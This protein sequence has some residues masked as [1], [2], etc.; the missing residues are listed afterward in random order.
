M[1]FWRY[2]MALR[3]TFSPAAPT[4]AVFLI[5]LRWPTPSAKPAAKVTLASCYDNGAAGVEQ[6]MAE[7]RNL[8]KKRDAS[9]RRVRGGQNQ[10]RDMFQ[11]LITFKLAE[12][13]SAGR[14]TRIP[15]TLLVPRVVVS[16]THRP[17]VRADTD[18]R[19]S[20][21]QGGHSTLAEVN[22]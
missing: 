2:T 14:S 18:L 9:E 7:A 10:R 17:C 15:A 3:F 8:Q 19:T 16:R 5:L 21:W 22:E 6:A 13:G 12:W 4:G 20:V 11:F 1:D